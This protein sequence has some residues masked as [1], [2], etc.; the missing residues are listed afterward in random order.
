MIISLLQQIIQQQQQMI[1]LLAYVAAILLALVAN[2][3][4]Y[5][6]TEAI[7]AAYEDSFLKH[8]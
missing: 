7:Q 1:N 2:T 5:K 8:H 3:A 4:V 6:S